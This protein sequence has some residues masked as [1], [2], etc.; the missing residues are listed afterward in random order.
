MGSG[1]NFIGKAEQSNIRNEINT[2]RSRQSRRQLV[3]SPEEVQVS[4]I[5][6]DCVRWRSMQL[7]AKI[8]EAN[9]EELGYLFLSRASKYDAKMIMIPEC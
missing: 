2:N 7:K 9:L 8:K 4:P 1:Q 3:E 6:F 5:Q